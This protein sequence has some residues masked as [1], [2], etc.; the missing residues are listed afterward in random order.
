MIRYAFEDTPGY[1]YFQLARQV[2]RALV[3]FE[4]CL[5]WVTESGVWRSNENLHLYYRL[6]ESYGDHTLLREC[7]AAL[8]LRHEEADLV[9]LIQLG[10]LFGCSARE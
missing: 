8:A 7:P 3:D 5:L 6:R 9:T 2:V 1:Q 10:M 4:E